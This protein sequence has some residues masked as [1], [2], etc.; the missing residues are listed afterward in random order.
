[1][2]NKRNL[3][4]A[5]TRPLKQ[6]F[7]SVLLE[8]M[9]FRIFTWVFMN[10]VLIGYRGSGKS[11]V[12]KKSAGRLGM[13]FVDTDDLLQREHRMSIREIVEACGWEYFRAAEKRLIGEIALKNHLVIASGGGAVLD[14][15]NVT[16]L[17]RNGL[18]IWLRADSQTLL[19]RMG[20]D[21]QTL[22]CRPSLTGKRLSEEIGELLTYRNQFY[23]RAAA[24]EIDTSAMGV[25]T[26]VQH[27]LE[28]CRNNTTPPVEKT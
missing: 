10:I 14:A 19:R 27:I 21:P 6:Q 12:G 15:E 17:R 2:F 4:L 22:G 1:M 3:K 9:D 13:K 18:M 7:G 24:F 11:T 25:E 28:L 26:V 20:E 5:A 8:T 23:K 16:A